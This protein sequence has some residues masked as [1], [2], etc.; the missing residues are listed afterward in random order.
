MPRSTR[1]KSEARNIAED[2]IKCHVG[3]RIRQIRR[4][5][6]MTQAQLG[7]AVGV[8]FQ[9]I[10]KYESGRSTISSAR[11]FRIAGALEDVISSFFFGLEEP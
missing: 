4:R 10:Q 1:T 5:K 3:R 6:G 11:L 2:D 8:T 7:S 9:Q